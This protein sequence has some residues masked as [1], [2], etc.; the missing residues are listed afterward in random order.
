MKKKVL[1]ALFVMFLSVNS[2]VCAN[3]VEK[4]NECPENRSILTDLGRDY[5]IEYRMAAFV[6]RSKQFRDIYC[7]AGCSYQIEASTSLYKCVYGWVNFDWFSKHG[8][9]SLYESTQISLANTSFGIRSLYTFDDHFTGY[10]GIGACIA[11]VSINNKLIG[12]RE[13]PSKVAYGGVFK[14]GFYFS[15]TSRIYVDTF[16]DYLYQPVHFNSKRDVGGLKLGAGVGV[17]F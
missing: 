6:P 8:H 14:S 5:F 4:K 1:Y 12:G 16:F 2:Y 7:E 15:V 11:N 17:R 13:H 9:S 10:V 3:D